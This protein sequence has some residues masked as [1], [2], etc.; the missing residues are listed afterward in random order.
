[1]KRTWIIILGLLALISCHNTSQQNG[2][3]PSE[4]CVWKNGQWATDWMQ[5]YV[6][7]VRGNDRF[8]ANSR[9]IDIW[10]TWGLAYIDDDATPEMVLFCPGEAYGNKVLT[11]HDGKVIE[12]NSW[13]CNASY[14][15]KSGL[16]E[17]KDGSM[18]E[19]WDKV[20]LLKDGA[21]TEIFNH[22]DK[23]FRSHDKIDDTTGADEYYCYFGSDSTLRIGF[24]M[25]CKEYHSQK[26]SLF[27]SVG[28]IIELCSIDHLSASLFEVGWTPGSVSTGEYTINLIVK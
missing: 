4:V 17:N 27:S 13:R 8:F 28:E 2:T 3:E 26:D 18:G 15:P 19:Y 14:I 10:N 7:Y 5:K 16:I 20:F 9:I 1:M 23:L 11:I 24:E 25:E 6:E 21:F 22:T 12:W